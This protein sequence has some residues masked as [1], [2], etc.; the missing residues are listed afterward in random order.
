M[1]RGDVQAYGTL[2]ERYERAVLAAVLS[3]VRDAHAAQD[4]AQ[5]VFVQCYTRLGSLRDGSRF[6][7]WLLKTAGREAIHA[8][9]RSRRMRIE[10]S[11]ATDVGVP[12]P[13]DLMLDDERERLLQCVR[14]LPAHERLAVSLRYFEGCGV[15][16][17]A[18]VT[19]RAVGT[20]TKQL[21]RAIE[22]LGDHLNK[23]SKS[24]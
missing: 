19:G 14:S 4:V 9:R 22:R 10:R 13:D 16:E 3:V 7:P 18:T 21:S 17:I 11:D 6:G 5:D 8:S 23:D 1:L 20:I 12:M 24:W 15:Q 2:V